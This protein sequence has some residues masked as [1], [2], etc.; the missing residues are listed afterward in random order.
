MHQPRVE[1]TATQPPAKTIDVISTPPAPVVEQKPIEKPKPKPLPEARD[2]HG[3]PIGLDSPVTV[4]SGIG[5]AIAEKLERLGVKTIRDVLYLFPRRY[6]DIAISSPSI[7]CS[8]AM[9]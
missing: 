4:I 3:N 2:E 8:T 1:S 6:D 9:K 7:V 5:P